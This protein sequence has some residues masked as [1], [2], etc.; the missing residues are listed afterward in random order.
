MKKNPNV[1]VFFAALT[2][3]VIAQAT[4]YGQWK[5]KTLNIAL[6]SESISVPFGQIVPVPVHPGISIGTD[7]L[8]KDQTS[9]YRSLG[10]EA[11]Y[12]YHE[13]YE[14]AVMLDVVYQ[15]GYTFGFKLQV[16]LKGMLGYT[17]SFLT[18]K[19]FV[20]EDGEYVEKRHPG[21]PQVNTKIGFGLQYP[22]HDRV[23]ITGDY[24]GMIAVPYSPDTG[25]PFATHGLL[26]IGAR[27]R[28]Q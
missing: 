5:P 2:I 11:G 15:F 23:S 4:M 9:W 20:L 1:K 3:I 27:I 6:V 26:R 18:G 22:V 17:H 28:F 10:V 13:L 25:M 8:V 21:Q 12:Y 7:L 19:T 24:L 16:N 14:H